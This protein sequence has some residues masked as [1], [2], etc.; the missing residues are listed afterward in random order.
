[1]SKSLDWSELEGKVTD[2]LYNAV[3]GLGFE[4]MTPVQAAVIPNFS[5]NKDVVVEAVTGSGKTLSFVVPVVDRLTK[6]ENITKKRAIYGVVVAPTRELALQISKVF[7]SMLKF[8]PEEDAIKIQNLVG[9]VQSIED[10]IRQYKKN[11]PQIIVGTPGRLA[12]FFHKITPKN[13]EVLVF[14]EADRLLDASFQKEID[15]ILSSL[16]KQKRVGLFSATM[17]SDVATQNLHRTGLRNPVRIVVNSKGHK[18]NTL[19]LS[20]SLVSPDQKI[21]HLIS[22]LN[23]FHFRKSIVYFPTCVSVEHFYLLFRH[24]STHYNLGL[25][26]YSLHGKLKTQARIKTLDKFENN[27]DSKSVLL[28][29]DVAAR[30]I[31][32]ENVDLVVQLDP[33]QDPDV[34][35][36]RCGRAGRANNTGYAIT[37]LT[38]GREED[39]IDFLQV[40]GTE[41]EQFEKKVPRI[42]GFQ[43]LVKKWMLQDRL[44]HDK[45]V[46]SF[47]SYVRYYSKHTATSIFRVQSLD[48]VGLGKAYGLFRLPKMPEISSHVK[49][50]KDGFI[51]D[52]VDFKGYKYADE[53]KEVKRLEEL[54]A[55]EK[56]AQNKEKRLE[57]KKKDL[58]NV[59]W[60]KSNNTKQDRSDRFQQS[61]AAKR[62]RE[63]ELVESDDE[64]EQKDWKDLIRESKKEKKQKKQQAIMG[65]FDDL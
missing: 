9:G 40:R 39:Y 46:R 27:H 48:Y 44:R 58:T 59:A 38:E 45:A 6:L 50:V 28:T 13:V 18:P 7:E 56:K 14:D 49:D 33:P 65:D 42:D 41:L 1:M 8:Q 11:T 3:V 61:D 51:D 36:H 32:V 22:I 63:M 60:S 54:K 64:A 47:V 24:I 15:F 30:G 34:F 52:T 12:E 2:W 20:Y 26:F 29:T 16:P 19:H 35:V 25:S 21:E 62:K 5:L 53:Q 57:K 17:L 43:Q 10:D 55:E 23:T 37:L 4:K 31:D